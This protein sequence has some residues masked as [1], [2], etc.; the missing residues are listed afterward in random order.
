MIPP[1]PGSATFD[2]RFKV[3]QNWSNIMSTKKGRVFPKAEAHELDGRLVRKA[4]RSNSNRRKTA[5]KSRSKS[6]H[7]ELHNH[8]HHSCEHTRGSD[9][10][11]CTVPL[12]T[13]QISEG[14]EFCSDNTVTAC[15]RASAIVLTRNA[16]AIRRNCPASRNSNRTGSPSVRRR[17]LVVSG[18][19]VLGKEVGAI[20][21]RRLKQEAMRVAW[22]NRE[23]AVPYT[24]GICR[25]PPSIVTIHRHRPMN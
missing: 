23:R 17:F 11:R 25:F 20:E 10:K 16:A 1:G 13:C 24:T 18:H 19:P 22:G 7:P 2:A 9:M 14:K 8:S 3:L 15:R 5:E 4:Q 21:R 12:C 6:P